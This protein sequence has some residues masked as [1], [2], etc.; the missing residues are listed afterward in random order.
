MGDDA[1][2]VGGAR[3]RQ[4]LTRAFRISQRPR[5]RRRRRRPSVSGVESARVDEEVS[6]KVVVERRSAAGEG[7]RSVEMET[8]PPVGLTAQSVAFFRR[9][10]AV[11][12]EPAQ[13]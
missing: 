8:R 6:L 12:S 7:Q 5:G 2:T 10:D 11:V 13:G 9:T 4:Q 3:R 1:E